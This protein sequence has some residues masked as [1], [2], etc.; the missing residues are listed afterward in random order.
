MFLSCWK[1]VR[2]PN[3]KTFF[4]P[5]KPLQVSFFFPPFKKQKKITS[6]EERRSELSC[7]E[8]SSPVCA[9]V[10]TAFPLFPSKCGKGRLP[11]GTRSKAQGHPD[12][13]SARQPESWCLAWA[14]CSGNCWQPGIPPFLPTAGWFCTYLA[15]FRTAP[16][17]V[18]INDRSSRGW[19][20]Y[21]MGLAVRAVVVLNIFSLSCPQEIK[22]VKHTLT[23]PLTNQCWHITLWV[24]WGRC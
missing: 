23:K 1:S 17:A 11:A 22:L 13:V 18:F 16:P 2:N 8:S 3:S 6:L 15:A 24:L 21:F 12:V 5:I 20:R 10:A 14:C 4:F 7:F 9:R 19:W